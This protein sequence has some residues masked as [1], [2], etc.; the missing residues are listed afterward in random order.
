M[1]M[2]KRLFAAALS[3][4]MILS[5]GCT[6]SNI[7]HP[8][9]TGR[10]QPDF[11]I[12]TDVIL[13]WDQ[14]SDDVSSYYED[15][16]YPGL[17]YFNYAHRDEEKT[18]EAKLFVDNTVEKEKAVEYAADLIRYINDSAVTQDNS[19]AMSTAD[20]YGGLFADYGF[21]VCVIPEE[22]EADESTWLVDMTV[23]AGEDTPIVPTE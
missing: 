12:V 16:E 19:L 23:P 22:T 1:L 17:L 20:S 18:I 8:E 7:L 13:D 5:A 4:V 21:R 11:T 2:K 9:E 6:K 3:C 10:P 15:I 14:I